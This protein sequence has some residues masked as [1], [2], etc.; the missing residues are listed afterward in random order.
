MRWVPFRCR[1]L[2]LRLSVFYHG[3]LSDQLGGE[4]G[5]LFAAGVGPGIYVCIVGSVASLL[6]ALGTFLP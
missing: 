5:G 1:G 3:I 6:G 2:G 4:S